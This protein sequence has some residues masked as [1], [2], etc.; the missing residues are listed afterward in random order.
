VFDVKTRESESMSSIYGPVERM[1]RSI[2]DASDS[3]FESDM[4]Q[5]LD[6]TDWTT[7]VGLENVMAEWDGVLGYAGLN[8]F[9]L[10]RNATTGVSR[11]ISWDK[12]NT[13]RSP[14]YFIRE[15]ISGNVLA[16]RLTSIRSYAD[17]YYNVLKVGADSIDEPMT[18]L[19]EGAAPVRWLRY[20]IDRIYLQIRDAML[21]DTAKP[22][23]NDEFEASVEQLRTFAAERPA[24]LRCEVMKETSR[25]QTAIEAACRNAPGQ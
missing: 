2:N 17:H 5:Y 13:F 9:Y 23:T 7:H 22:H 6:L 8:N 1:V 11:F 4:S 18:G 15:G 14:T 16:R 12:D 21:A 3:S 19:P 10:Y 25:D 24:Y 20:H